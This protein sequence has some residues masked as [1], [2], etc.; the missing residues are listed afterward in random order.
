[1]DV[2][3]AIARIRKALRGRSGKNWSVIEDPRRRGSIRIAPPW[4]LF[5]KDE[6]SYDNGWLELFRL[7]GLTA[8]AFDVGYVSASDLDEY[9]ARAERHYHD[10]GPEG[11]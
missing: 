7:L 10:D 4:R 11:P 8:P 9:V 1:M 5:D 3:E 2:H 6:E